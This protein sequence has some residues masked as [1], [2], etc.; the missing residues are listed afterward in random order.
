MST[1]AHPRESFPVGP[2]GG[3]FPATA[4]TATGPTSRPWILRFAR[5]P[6]SEQASVVP[7]TVYD[8]T[9]QMSLT[10]DGD[11][12]TCM[13]KTHSPTVPDGNVKNPPP[14]DEGTKD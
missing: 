12:V 5:V 10:L 3:H 2:E 6:D 1:V 8:E 9:L 7:E 13:A 4:E 11:F 14:L